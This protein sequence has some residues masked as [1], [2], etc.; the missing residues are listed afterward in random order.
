[1]P[2][3]GFEGVVVDVKDGALQ[4]VWASDGT[5]GHFRGAYGQ[6]TLF[7]TVQPDGTERFYHGP[8]GEETVYKVVHHHLGIVQYANGKRV[9]KSTWRS[10]TRLHT[11]Y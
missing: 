7:K 4:R 3:Q 8:T 2:V 11:F 1:M 5:V 9:W 6:E 10:A